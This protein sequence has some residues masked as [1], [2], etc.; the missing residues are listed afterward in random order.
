M[1]VSFAGLG[2]LAFY[3]AGKL[4]LFDRRGHAVRS[5]HF[6]RVVILADIRHVDRVKHGWRL[7]PL[8]VLLW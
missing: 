3:T 2:F 7:R 5:C 8:L 1:Q 4:H 6:T